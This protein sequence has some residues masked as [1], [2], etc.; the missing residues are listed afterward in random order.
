MARKHMSNLFKEKNV[1]LSNL[2]GN[3]AL[4]TKFDSWFTYCVLSQQKSISVEFVR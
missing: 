2:R 1:E 4:S 3:F